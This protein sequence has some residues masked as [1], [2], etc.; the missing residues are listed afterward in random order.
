M[1]ASA[2]KAVAE[3]DWREL[4]RLTSELVKAEAKQKEAISNNSIREQ[5][6]HKARANLQRMET[7][8]GIIKDMVNAR[9]GETGGVAPSPSNATPLRYSTNLR[10]ADAQFTRFILADISD[11]NTF[12]VCRIAVATGKSGDDS[13][14]KGVEDAAEDASEGAVED[15]IHGR[16]T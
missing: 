16:L 2:A 9:L 15:T 1:Q 13:V 12:P 14:E 10:G 3:K 5:N 6:Q 8:F 7:S 4:G 11:K